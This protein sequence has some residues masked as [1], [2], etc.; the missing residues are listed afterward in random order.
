MRQLITI[1]RHIID[2]QKRHPEATGDFSSLLYDLCFATK[3]ISSE[4]N[5]AGLVGILGCAGK[6]NVQGE[7]V[8]KLDEYANNVIKNSMYHTGRCCV[9]ASEEEEGIIPIPPEYP[10]GKYVLLFD[11][12]DGSSNIDSNGCIGTIFAI[13]RKISPGP[14]GTVQDCLQ[15]GSRL[16]ASGYVIYG[17]S[18]MLVFSAGHGVHG[19]TLDPSIGEYLLSHPDIRIPERGRIL[20]VNEGHRAYWHENVRR[21]V[22]G[23]KEVNPALG[24]PYT[25]R[26]MGAL[27][28]DFHRNLLYGGVYLYPRVYKGEGPGQGKLRLQYEASPLAYLCEQ[29]GGAATDGHRRILDIEPESIHQRV[30]LVIGSRADVDEATRA[31]G[32]EA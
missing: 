4:V 3:V 2:Q 24:R 23:L 8:Q 14:D 27:V 26:Y 30:P 15:K 11:P 10:R 28:A 9:M 16:V 12:L 21:Y 7:T 29:A 1:E 6:E 25:A 18:T 31:F 22:D 17:S 19:Y 20:S 5:K 13:F 32:P